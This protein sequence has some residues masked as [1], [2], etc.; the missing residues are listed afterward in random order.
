MD[1]DGFIDRFD[2]LD[3]FDLNGWICVDR[4]PQNRL[5]AVVVS[6]ALHSA[7]AAPKK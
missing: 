1:F 7:A 3:A 4:M 5:V 6:T 2:G